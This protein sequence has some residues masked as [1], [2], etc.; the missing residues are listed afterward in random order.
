MGLFAVAY[1]EAYDTDTWSSGT[2]YK[3]LVKNTGKDCLHAHA[4]SALLN[5][6]IVF[7]DEV[8]MVLNYIVEFK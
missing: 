4:G 6:E 1:G 5:D 7:Y 8:A 3:K 2:D